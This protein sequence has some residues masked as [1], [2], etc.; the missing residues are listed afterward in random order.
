MTERTWDDAI[1]Y[2]AGALATPPKRQVVNG[3]QWPRCTVWHITADDTYTLCGQRLDEHPSFEIRK[4]A[5]P[6]DPTC[7]RCR[8]AAYMANYSGYDEPPTIAR[9]R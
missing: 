3:A 9:R 1:R 4:P 6:D 5:N 7:K 2:V 8:F